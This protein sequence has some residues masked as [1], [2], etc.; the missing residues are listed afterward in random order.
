[1]PNCFAMA[2]AVVVTGNHYRMIPACMHAETAFCFVPWWIMPANPIKVNEDS[3]S[4]TFKGSNNARISFGIANNPITFVGY[5][6][7]FRSNA[8]TSGFDV[9]LFCLIV[10]SPLVITSIPFLFDVLLSCIFLTNRIRLFLEIF[11]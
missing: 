4:S 5:F 8:E 7:A 6:V 9:H 3:I 2:F 11:F 1:M 10:D